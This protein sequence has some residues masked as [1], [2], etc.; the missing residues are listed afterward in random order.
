[1]KTLMEK[2]KKPKHGGRHTQNDEENGENDK[3]H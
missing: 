1:M 2:K 3:T